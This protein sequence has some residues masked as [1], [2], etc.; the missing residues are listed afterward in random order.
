MFDGSTNL[1][2]AKNVLSNLRKG[3][4][5]VSIWSLDGMKELW[6]GWMES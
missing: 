3:G 2:M 1:D 6:N 5:L 4:T